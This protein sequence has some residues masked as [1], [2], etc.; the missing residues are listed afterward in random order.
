MTKDI[1]FCVRIKR[2]DKLD[3]SKAAQMIGL[4]YSSF[5]RSAALEKAKRLLRDLESLQSPEV[6]A[7]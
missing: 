6:L 3:I 4:K 1:Q 5:I 2:E 7:E